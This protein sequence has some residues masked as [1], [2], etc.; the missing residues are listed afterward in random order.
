MNDLHS[1]ARCP[2]H[3]SVLLRADVPCHACVADR[4]ACSEPCMRILSL[5]SIVRA[6]TDRVAVLER[7]RRVALDAGAAYV[8]EHDDTRE[9]PAVR[10]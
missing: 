3:P 4:E 5:E 6:L 8:S 7:P 9:L 1:S 2:R 10:P